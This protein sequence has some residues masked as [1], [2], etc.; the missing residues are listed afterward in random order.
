MF[1]RH[2]LS[3]D[4]CLQH[5]VTRPSPVP[6]ATQETCS[7]GHPCLTSA[8]SSC[9]AGRL[10]PEHEP[11]PFAELARGR[12]PPMTRTAR[13]RAEVSKAIRLTRMVALVTIGAL[14]L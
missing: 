7:C 12:R 14:V 13:P 1:P 6:S 2:L 9:Q 5:V 8:T 10:V 4:T 3:N 11:A